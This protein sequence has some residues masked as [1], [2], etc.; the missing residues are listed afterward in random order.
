MTRNMIG[1]DASSQLQ[2]DLLSSIRDGMNTK[3]PVLVHLNADTTWLLQ[4]PYPPGASRP[5][6]RYRF[7]ILIDPWLKGNQ[8]DVGAWFSSQWHSI[9]SCIQSIAELNQLLHD[10]EALEE[11]QDSIGGTNGQ[12]EAQNRIDAVVIS[13]EFTDHCHKQTLLEIDP[14]IPVI[15][16][17][18]GAGGA[19][20]LIRSW[21]HFDTVLETPPF[22][23]ELSDWQAT[24]SW[25]LPNWI[26]VSRIVSASD[27]LNYHSAVLIAFNLHEAKKE[28]DQDASHEAEAVV[29]TPHGISGP[30][31]RCLKV[32][33][34]PIHIL[35]LLHGLHDIK[36]SIK[37]LNLGAHNGLQA[38]RMCNAKYWVGPH[39]EIKHAGGFVKKVLHRKV[40]TLKEALDAE[41][42]EKGGM[43]PADS[44]L[45]D[46]A[47]VSFAELASGE[48]LLLL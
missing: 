18:A 25:P 30:D 40:L 47:N 4:L 43:I 22:S 19:A 13:H 17:N 36:V 14:R 37:Q 45:A 2:E 33:K 5:P 34:P 44:M 48:S 39:D 26:E 7:N 1:G 23:E 32:A 41:R 27:V 8:F 20:N 16:T 28:V 15:A 12:I 10:N 11:G 3:R 35:A 24:S 38:Q 29:Y 9:S 21:R 46:M 6:N 31:L 42:N